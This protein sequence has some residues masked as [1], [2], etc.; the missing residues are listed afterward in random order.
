[1]AQLQIGVCT[2]SL[3]LP[4]MGETFAA[5]RNQLNLNVVHLGFF[6]DS[7]YKEPNKVIDQVKAA[8]LTVSATC[9][10]FAGED[11]S[12]IQAIAR[13]GGYMPDDLFAERFAKTVAVADITPRLGTTCWPSNRFVPEDPKDPKHAG[14]RA[15]RKLADALGSAASR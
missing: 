15:A 12:S 4:D 8:G 11:Y 1:M 5:V 14:W 6:D 13:T 7:Y 10:A 3:H 9:V 2:W